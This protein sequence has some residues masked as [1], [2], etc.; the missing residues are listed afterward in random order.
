A[1]CTATGQIITCT[2][3]AGT[4]PGTYS[5][6]YAAT[7]N[8]TAAGSVSNAVVATGGSSS[9]PTCTSCTTTH[10]V[11][12]A[13]ITV[14]KSASPASG[15]AVAAGD[16]IDYSLQAVISS[17]ASTSDLVLTDTL[18][19]GQTLGTLPAG[20]T[21]TGQVITCT[22]PAGTVPGTYH[23]AYQATVN[24][25]ATGSVSNRVVPTGGSS[26]APTCSN[27]TTTH[28]ITAAAITVSKSASPASGTEVKVASS[29]AYTLKTVISSTSSTSDLILRD[30][31]SPGQTAGVMPPG[32]TI[33]GQIITC[34]IPGGTA[35]GTYNFQYSATVNKNASG[36]VSNA[37][38]AS[39]GSSTA[40][41]CS[42][43]ATA[44]PVKPVDEGSLSLDVTSNL[45]SFSEPG[46][47][48]IYT[49]DTTNTGRLTL[50]NVKFKDSSTVAISCP[51]TT[52]TPGQ[53]MICTGSYVTTLADVKNGGIT[54]TAIVTATLAVPRTRE[55]VEETIEVT[56]TTVASVLVVLDPTLI[57]DQTQEMVNAFLT[58]RA[59]VLLANQPDR[60]R[61][62]NRLNAASACIGS[63]D[64]SISP[65][66][67]NFNLN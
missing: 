9:A 14:S 29:I 3:P 33:A 57:Q 55:A 40:P 23:F 38:T 48:I 34:I 5:F 63:P 27:C 60:R 31:L 22:V 67:N 7:V 35:P 52:L 53:N 6:T 16:H 30:T 61:I 8:Q 32:C 18:S 66:M 47:T 58:T 17:A 20:C 15:T 65:G 13:A 11:T 36:S 54:Q 37:V 50:N 42:Q 51:E 59:Q 41:A 46:T 49:Y 25:T 56:V 43:C 39:G 28:P 4:V 2:I 24:Q 26:T 21:A 44:H 62:I 19:A 1:G 10:P 64:V 45:K 12:A